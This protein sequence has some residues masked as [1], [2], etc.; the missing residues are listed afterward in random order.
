ML[1]FNPWSD[2][3]LEYFLESL[4]ETLTRIQS[5]VFI[6]ACLPWLTYQRSSIC[7]LAKPTLPCSATFEQLIMVC[8]KQL[9]YA[10]PDL[11]LKNK[12]ANVLLSM[13]FA[14]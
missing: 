1:T 8:F 5:T 9:F 3:R 10:F 6:H 14:N 4:I 12:F 13:R 7:K 11:I 2:C